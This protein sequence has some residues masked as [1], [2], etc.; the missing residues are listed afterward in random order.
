MNHVDFFDLDAEREARR[1][2]DTIPAPGHTLES[3]AAGLHDLTND[4][5]ALRA[6]VNAIADKLGVNR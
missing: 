6:V 2:A 1:Q 5:R 4:V 3:L